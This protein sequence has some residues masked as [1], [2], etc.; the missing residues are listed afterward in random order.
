PVERAVGELS[1]ALMPFSALAGAVPGKD[2]NRLRKLAERVDPTTEPV[3]GQLLL[4]RA[5]RVAGDDQLAER[6]LRAA[7][8]ARPQDLILRYALGKL[9]EVQRPPKWQEA[10]ACYEAARALRPQLGLALA[11]ALMQSGQAEQGL[12]MYERLVAEKPENPWIHIYYAGALYHQRRYRE[13]EARDREALKLQPDYHVAH[14]NLGNSLL[15][16]RR[17]REAE[18]AYHEATRLNPKDPLAFNN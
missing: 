5:L 16:Q 6:L 8:R 10:I 18:L 4:A 7:V 11:E 2:R 17:Y 12:E 13:A 9:L 15:G 14:Y 3:L 1:R